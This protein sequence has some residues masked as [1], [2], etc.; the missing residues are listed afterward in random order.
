MNIKRRVLLTF[1]VAVFSLLIAI[2]AYFPGPLKSRMLI[3]LDRGSI[4]SVAKT[5]KK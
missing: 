1:I 5:L 4:Y 3:V 2:T